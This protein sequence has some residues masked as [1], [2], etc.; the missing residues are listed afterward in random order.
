MTGIVINSPIDDALINVVHLWTLKS[1]DNMSPFL[2]GPQK[3]LLGMQHGNITVI[4]NANGKFIGVKFS[5]ARLATGVGYHS[6][7]S[8]VR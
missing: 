7:K 3:V 6:H 2:K 4:I 1:V 8:D 5:L